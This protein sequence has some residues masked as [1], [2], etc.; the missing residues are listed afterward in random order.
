MYFEGDDI[1]TLHL[2]GFVMGMSWLGKTNDWTRV[3]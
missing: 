1:N 2:R 3:K